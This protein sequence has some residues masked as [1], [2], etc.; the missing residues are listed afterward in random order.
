MRI[1]LVRTERSDEGT[2]GFLDVN[3]TLLRTAEPP[4]R[5]NQRSISSIPYGIYE[6]SLVDSPR[7]GITYQVHDVPGR[8]HILFHAGNW[9]GDTSKGLISNTDGCILPGM[10]LDHLSGQKAVVS[11]TKALNKLFELTNKEPFTLYV[12]GLDI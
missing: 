12:S 11:S 8:T 7:F 2:F 10:N 1:H 6:C 9:A 3:G 5:N 4:W